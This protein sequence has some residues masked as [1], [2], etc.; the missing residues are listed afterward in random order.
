MTAAAALALWLKD[1]TANFGG[2]A[3]HSEAIGD[4]RGKGSFSHAA[5]YPAAALG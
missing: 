5:F 4:W 2:E 1:R 3:A